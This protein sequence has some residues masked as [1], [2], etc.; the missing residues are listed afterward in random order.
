MHTKVYMAP[1]T[2]IQM[3]RINSLIEPKLKN[4]NTPKNLKWRKYEWTFTLN[5]EKIMKN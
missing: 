5:T 4:I 3:I 1:F 2:L